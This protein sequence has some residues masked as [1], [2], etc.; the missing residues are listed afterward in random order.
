MMKKYM[1]N[2]LKLLSVLLILLIGFSLIANF[3]YDITPV[4]YLRY[5]LPLTPAEKKYLE[6]KDTITYGLDWKAPPLTYINE[7]TGQVEGLLIDYMSALSI[8]LGINV[9][10]DAAAFSH[11]M[12]RLDQGITDMS[13]LFESPERLKKYVFTQP[14]YRLRGIAVTT[15]DRRDLQDEAALTGKRIGLVE[16]DFA[17]EHFTEYYSPKETGTV[18][19]MVKDMQEG[20]GLLLDGQVDALAGDETVIDYYVKELDLKET[21]REV[22][23]GLYEKNVTFA[24]KKDDQILLS[25]L[26]KGILNLKKK[27]ILVQGQQKWFDSSAPV[28]TDITTM[29]WLPAVVVLCLILLFLFFGWE[30]IMEKRIT[31][32]TREIQVQK[33]NLRTVIDNIHAMLLVTSRD[34]VIRDMNQL[35]LSV[36]GNQQEPLIGR[37]MMSIPLLSSLMEAYQSEPD[38]LYLVQGRYY[39]VFVRSLNAVDGSQ[40][41][42]IEDQTNKT[43]AER[44]LRQE[45]KMIAVGQLSAG[46]AHEIRNPLGLIRNYSYILKGYADDE[47]SSHALEVIGD[48]TNRINSLIENLLNFSRSG[49]ENV[50]LVDIGA[51]LNN[52]A[53][54]EHKKMEKAQIDFQIHCAPHTR[55]FT[56][57]ETLK[58]VLINLINNGLEALM[59]MEESLSPHGRKL[60]CTVTIVDSVLTIQVADNGPGIPEKNQESIFNPF[61][62]T[63]DTGTGLGLYLVSS[64]LEKLGGSIQV[65][66]RI[67]EGTVFTVSLP[68]KQ[69]GNSNHE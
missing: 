62:T 44:K 27:N 16:D 49:D 67:R 24:V 37:A 21:I 46:L 39:T 11:I 2:T 55:F 17:V 56:N 7:E 69:E 34:Y 41:I 26:N 35:A 14:L 57:E 12:D 40:L 42:V 23:D 10:Y 15:S 60:T 30:S 65:E 32:K 63:K 45:S 8:E 28:F 66:S 13:D 48:S 22:G 64:E 54:L 4:E 47:I 38:K 59:E 36:L 33:D 58:I 9:T 3:Q 29:D 50:W 1:K 53:A 5:S 43:L 19:V 68:E 51:L 25:I 6:E 18:F 52:I 61:F 31:E 20:L